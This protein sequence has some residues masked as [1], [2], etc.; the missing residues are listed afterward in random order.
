MNINDKINGDYFLW[1]RFRQG[2]KNAL[3]EI[4]K[5]H[6]SWLFDYGMRIRNDKDFIQERIQEIFYHLISNIHSLGPIY[7]LRA[8]LLA[9]L[10]R[11]IFSELRNRQKFQLKD[12]T[13]SY[14]F[15]FELSHENV[16]IER[17][18]RKKRKSDLKKLINKLPGR[19]K[20]AVYLKFY[21]DM[22]YSEI[23]QV[24]GVSYDS[25]R[26]LIYRAIKSLRNMTGVDI[27]DHIPSSQNN[28]L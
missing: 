25:S 27:T 8:Y 19:E 7:N 17:E 26:K 10:R 9:S 24:M 14:D 4:Y 13:Q 11:K 2:D 5:S 20:E 16:M 28:S 12:T 22:S 21:K 18:T 15:D 1:E 3:S 23:M 6:Y